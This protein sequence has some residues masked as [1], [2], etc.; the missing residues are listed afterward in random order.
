MTRIKR[1][2]IIVVTLFVIILTGCS[3]S[4]ETIKDREGKD[5]V[6]PDKVDRIIS[7]APSN[8]EI[9]VGLG[10]GDKIVAVDTFSEGIEG[11]K[12]DIPK[13]DFTNPDNEKLITLK[14]DIIIASEINKSG[15]VGEPLSGV[16]ES[17]VTTVY[18]PTSN[19]IEDIYKDI[20]FIAS[21]ASR[22]EEGEK[23][24]NGM[25]DSIEKTKRTSKEIKNKKKVYFEIDS[26]PT[27]YSFGSETFLNE[28]IEIIGAEN[29]LKDERLWVSPTDESI[30]KKNPDVILTNKSFEKNVEESIKSRTG[31]ENVKAIK[32]NNVHVIDI[33][34]SSR[35][36]QN[37]IKALNEMSRA[38]YP[39]NYEK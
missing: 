30:I 36:S 8:T 13:I 3:S 16:Q 20:E 18:I 29:I 23:I 5:I 7:T 14:P 27:L 32:E 24:I 6:L 37:I 35:P 4:G 31:W 2:F 17:G 26:E 38:I 25:K 19:S 34:S 12:K 21:V 10:L 11:I 28:M 1:K 33:N 9:L 22:K 39:E 15:S